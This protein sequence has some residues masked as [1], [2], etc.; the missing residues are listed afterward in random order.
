MSR[1]A[2]YLLVILCCNLAFAAELPGPD[3]AALLPQ[4]SHPHGQ[5]S[6][7][8]HLDELETIAAANNPEIM[9]MMRRVALAATRIR[10]AGALDD[11]QFM[12]RGWGTPLARPWDMDQTQHMFMYSQS[13]PGPGKRALRSEI[14]SDDVNVMKAQLEARKREVIAEVR[15]AFYDLLRNQEELALHDQHLTLARQSLE[16]TKIKYV[17]G[18]VPQQDVLKAQI[19]LTKL[20]EHLVMFDQDGSLAR[21]RLNTLLGRDPGTSLEVE[22]E[23]V[24]PTKLPSL[25]DLERLALENR[26]ELVAASVTVH[27]EE[28]RSNL[29]KKGLTPD[30][31]L[32]TGYMLM[33][34]GSQ[35]RNTYMAE[36]SVTLPWL[37]RGRHNAEIAEAEAS[38]ALQKA[39]YENQR[40]LVFQQVQEAL[41]RA[42]A[43]RQ[44][45]DLYRSTL[46]PQAQTTLQA[47]VAA[48]QTDR[49]DFLNLLD[50]Q[51][52][53]LDVELNY[54]RTAE[55]LESAIADLERAV[56][57][58]L[59]R[60]EI[61]GPATLIAP[62]TQAQVEVQQ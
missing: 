16:A 31:G 58:T 42:Q 23:Y 4:H 55:E 56:G 22:G 53:S 11:P 36:L 39:E 27:Q 21:A 49:T 33:P 26:P 14:A 62:G 19:A 43:A 28:S 8:L 60:N 3:L 45:V 29:A 38:V 35:F 30:Y 17:V 54:F 47:A 41:V 9:V 37:N 20:V 15:K 12:Y 48:Y 59:P 57:T 32:T 7:P 46:R 34:A 10:T 24:P 52:M 50:S 25:V 6:A 2:F 13:L 18:R 40:T 61:S 51:N 44:L 5:Q 1:Q